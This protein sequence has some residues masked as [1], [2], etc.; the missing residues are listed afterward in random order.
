MCVL[1]QT[2]FAQQD[3]QNTFFMYNQ[4][5]YNPASVGSKGFASINVLYRQQWLGFEGAPVSQVLTFDAPLAG[6]RVGLG[7]SVR[8][9]TIG[10]NTDWRAAMAYSYKMQITPDAALR[11]GIQGSI[12][13][14]GMNFNNSSV[15][16]DKLNDQSFSDGVMTRLYRGNIGAGLYFTYKN[17]VWAGISTPAFYPITLGRN[18]DVDMTATAIAHFYGAFGA[19]L[20]INNDIQLKPSFLVKYAQNAPIDVDINASVILKRML[21]LGASYRLGGDNIGDS[22]DFMAGYQV[23]HNLLLGAAYDMTIS[24]LKDHNNGSFE[25]L[26]RYDIKSEKGDLDNPRF[27]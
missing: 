1:S 12:H 10:I 2:A 11:F 8:H 4:G 14:L 22:I 23:L 24:G 5:L 18:G 19:L 25:L 27:F 15:V 9:Y 20:D 21:M 7:V 3:P 13:Y 26:L 6:D 17:S 16:V